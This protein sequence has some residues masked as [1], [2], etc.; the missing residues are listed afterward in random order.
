MGPAKL[1]ARGLGKCFKT[2]GQVVDALASVDLALGDREFVS[3]IGPSG[4][5]KSTLF[6]IFAGLETPTTGDVM[7]DGKPRIGD[8]LLGKVGYMPQQDLLMPWRTILDNTILGL[9]I[10]GVA[11]PEAR[12][13]AIEL[14]P[15]F[16]LSGFEKR[17]PD[18]LSGGMRQ[19]AALLRT[20]LASREVNL[21]DEPFGA[22]DSLTRAAMQQWLISFWE[23]HRKSILFVTHDID[24]ALFLS[25][26][27]YAMSARPGRITQILEV[28]IPR[29]RSYEVITSEPFIEMK[30][31][32]LER[33]R[34]AHGP[35]RAA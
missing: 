9:E 22:L 2:R 17:Y 4:C 5:G 31:V 24:E 3:V 34:L 10:A 35:G 23:E 20:F 16:G 19:R 30:Q 18:A 11:K 26:R 29:P 7:L 21:L 14:F 27:V 6:N 28:N 15:L 33:L 32:L 1:E 13:R 12:A 8:D 25:D